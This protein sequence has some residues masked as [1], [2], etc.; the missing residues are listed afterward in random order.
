MKSSWD[1]KEANGFKDDPLTLRVYTS[2]LLGKESSLVLHGGGNTSVKALVR[3]AFGDMQ[4]VLY[5]K[6]SGWD[7]A[8]IEAKGFA[9]VKLEALKRMAAFE[10][11]SDTDMV[12]LQRA[13]MLDPNAPNPSVEAILHA[14]IPYKF[15]DHSHADAIVAITN[16]PDGRR[17]IEEIYGRDVMIVPYVM[18]GFVLAKKVYEMTKSLDWNTCKGIVLLNHGLFTFADNAKE[19]YEQHIRLVS[20]AEEYIKLERIKLAQKRGGNIPLEELACL[21]QAVSQL[22]KAAVVVHVKDDA[23]SV[24]FAHLPN[25][26]TI[27]TKGTLTPDHVIRTKPIPM[28][29]GTEPQADAV[30][31][32]KHYASYFERN[33]TGALK[34]LDLAP[35]WAIWPKTGLLTFGSSYK[36]ALIT[37]DIIDHTLQAIQWAEGMG[38]WRVISERDIFE[39]EY[40]ELEQAK[41]AKSDKAKS[42]QGKVALVSGSFSGIGKTTVEHLLASGAHVAA[43]DINKDILR[44]FNSRNVLPIICDVTKDKDIRLAVEKT[45][46]H[47][48]GLDI[49]VSNAGIFPASANI[50]DMD[51]K[52]WDKSVA[53]NLTSHQRLMTAAAKYLKYGIDPTIIIVGSKNVPAPGPGAAAYSVAKAGLTQLA[54]VAAL[55]MGAMGIRVNVVHPNQ[56]FDTAIWTKEVLAKRAKSYGLTVEEYKTNNILKTEITSTNVADLIVTMAGPAFSKTTGA[57]I[58]IDG[59]ND[60]VI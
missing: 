16:T 60:R 6:G 21:R 43:L 50:A 54:R 38:G 45:V 12:S 8:T 27:G 19:S 48:G 23:Y 52:V 57:Q 11:L 55:E 29:V 18:P 37:S 13:S 58:P 14:I 5:I 59:G 34:C 49:V 26:S 9:A 3:D 56:V 33:Q 30:K 2:R 41:L 1:Q 10:A 7:L 42:L 39:M 46:R 20:R 51:P 31:Y 36:D 4:E 32:S 44:A 53:I 17:R 22:Q 24:G 40:W 28:V 15:V 35:R 47:F 25:V